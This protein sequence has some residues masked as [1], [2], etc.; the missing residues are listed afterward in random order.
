MKISLGGLAFTIEED[1]YVALDAYLESLRQ[2]FKSS[3]EGEEIFRDME[4]RAA[5]LFTEM[6]ADK[7]VITLDMVRAVVERLG[8]PEQISDEEV[9]DNS[10]TSGQTSD[11]NTKRRLYRD[12]ENAYI[13]GVAAGLGA[14]FNIDPL[15]FRILFAVLIF[16][17]GL[18]AIIYLIFWAVLPQ[19]DTVR[20]RMEMRGEEI[21][22]SNLEKNIKNEFEKVTKNMKNKRFTDVIE[23]FGNAVGR[24]FVA[25]GGVLAVVGK[26]IAAIIAVVFIA[27]GLL[28]IMGAVLSLFLGDVVAAFLP[29]YSGFTFGQLLS[30]TFD[31]GSMLWVAIPLF[32]VVLIPFLA[33]IFIGLRMVF[34]FSVRG[35]VFFVSSATVWIVAVLIL[36][37]VMFMQARSFTI[38]ESVTE[39]FALSLSDSTSTTL[40]LVRDIDF[41]YGDYDPNKVWEIDDYTLAQRDGMA[42]IIGKPKVYLAK[43]EGPEFEMVI[44][45]RSR[46]ATRYTAKASASAVEV[47][48]ALVDNK[49]VIS[50]Y[51]F[52]PNSQKWR[53]QEVEITVFV[54]EGKSV[55]IENNMESLL[56]SDQEYC[57]CWPDEMV[58]NVW[59]MKGGKLK[60]Q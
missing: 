20:Q 3:D 13:A 50:P 53:V 30:S 41:D 42:K 15:V 52:I 36:A 27:V 1:A 9:T 21:N 8:S 10:S 32:V 44:K 57:A 33:I 56:A 45:K 49:L 23:R 60:K 14:Y 4:E 51:F 28:G 22:L 2:Y 5:E 47:E 7:Q 43:S 46:G 37:S 35:T 31:L 39:R 58:G 19:A 54:P 17:N 48:F 12:P 59:L 29:S 18:G 40:K 11:S 6:L 55:Y 34:R 26:V 24:L 38:R 25:L 16:A